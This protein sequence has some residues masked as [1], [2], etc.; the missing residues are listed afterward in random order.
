MHA[1]VYGYDYDCV[2]LVLSDLPGTLILAT[3]RRHSTISI[4]SFISNV[5]CS[6]LA[7][8]TQVMYVLMIACV[9][10]VCVCIGTPGNCQSRN[11]EYII[12]KNG[13]YNPNSWHNQLLAYSARGIWL[14]RI[15]R[16]AKDNIWYSPPPHKIAHAIF[17]HSQ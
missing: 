7:K 14:R 13:N 16:L 4:T 5:E 12:T 11:T 2:I 6:E 10:C 3:G 8:Y 9:R 1:A 15:F 17:V